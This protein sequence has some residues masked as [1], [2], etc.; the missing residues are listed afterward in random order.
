MLKNCRYRS[1]KEAKVHNFYQIEDA[2]RYL[3]VPFD[4]KLTH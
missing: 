2:L 3:K 4:A 1:N